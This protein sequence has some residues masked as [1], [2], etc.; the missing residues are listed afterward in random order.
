MIKSLLI[1]KLQTIAC[2]VDTLI[3]KMQPTRLTY[4]QLVHERDMMCKFYLDANEDCQKLIN[5]M[6]DMEKHIEELQEHI[7]TTEI[8]ENYRLWANSSWVGDSMDISDPTSV[9]YDPFNKDFEP[10]KHINLREKYWNHLEELIKE[11]ELLENEEMVLHIDSR[12]KTY[13]FALPK[14]VKESGAYHV[15]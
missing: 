7:R 2:S 4:E 12:S 14:L 6:M 13:P 3:N 1:K 5:K 8:N 15:K 9:M 11:K 10:D